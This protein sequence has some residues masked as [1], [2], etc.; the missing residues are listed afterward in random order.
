MDTRLSGVVI[1]VLCLAGCERADTTATSEP[2][3]EPITVVAPRVVEPPPAPPAIS[4]PRP[5]NPREL[6]PPVP[7]VRPRRTW[8]SQLS[9]SQRRDVREVCQA[10]KTDPCAG[11]LPRPRGPNDGPDRMAALLGQFSYE[12]R[13]RVTKWCWNNVSQERCDTPLVIAFD[14]DP[15]ALEPESDS[16]F[17]FHPGIPVATRWPTDRTPWLALDRDGDGKITSGEELFGDSTPLGDGR[18]APDGFA[19]LTALDANHDAVIDRRDPMF[20]ALVLWADRDANRTTDPGELSP[21]AATIVSISLA[22]DRYASAKITWRDA[23]GT[24]HDG[25]VWDI[26]LRSR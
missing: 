19:A 21:A 24:L 7:T 2:L 5:I 13:D 11:M 25:V 26:Y 18:T 16:T 3:R 4:V 10:R 8:F 17:A 23:R 6:P 1:T 9:A 20:A 22:P 15:I 12:D 14:E